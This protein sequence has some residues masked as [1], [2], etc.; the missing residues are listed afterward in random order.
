MNGMGFHE[1]A[2][3]VR[4]IGR[5]GVGGQGEQGN[6]FFRGGA[7]GVILRAVGLWKGGGPPGTCGCGPGGQG[8]QGGGQ[9]DD[10][11]IFHRQSIK[12]SRDF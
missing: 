6:N 8:E 11:K 4:F 12:Q 2:G 1:M 5:A 7:Y 10:Q 9:R 3:G